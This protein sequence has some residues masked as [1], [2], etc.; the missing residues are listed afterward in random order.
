MISALFSA[1]A[2]MLGP[3]HT[4]WSGG[5]VQAFAMDGNRMAWISGA[6]RTVRVRRLAGR[7]AT[8]LGDANVTDCDNRGTPMVALAGRRALWTVLTYGNFT[9]TYVFTRA[10]GERRKAKQIDYLVHRNDLEGDWVTALSGTGSMLAYGDAIVDARTLADETDVYAAHAGNV[11]RVV[12]RSKRI[13]GYWGLAPFRIAVSDRFVAIVPADPAEHQSAVLRPSSDGVAIRSLGGEAITALFPQ[14]PVRGLAVT[15]RYAALLASG[16]VLVYGLPDGV[17]RN[18]SVQR[19]TA[20][21]IDAYGARVVVRSGRDIWVVD[22]SSGRA[23]RV[24]TASAMP[25]GLSISGRTVAWA[26]NV[27]A[28]GRIRVVQVA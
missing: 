9:Y 11:R 13:L 5:L 17:L 3:P 19:F 15:T 16:R 28:R 27:R 24:A 12:G 8:V 4:V 22:A 25:I 6:C 14:I 1:V 23:R 21:D 20:P 2:L 18:M 7:S 26:E 10:V